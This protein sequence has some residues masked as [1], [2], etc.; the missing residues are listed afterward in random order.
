MK[1]SLRVFAKALLIH[2][3]RPLSPSLP[4]SGGGGRGEEEISSIPLSLTLSPLGGAREPAR[5]ALVLDCNKLRCALL[6]T[7]IGCLAILAGCTVGPDYH[8][9]KENPPTQWVSPQA[10]GE[11]N[12]QATETAWWKSFHDPELDSL[13]A[14]AAQSNLSM[15]VAVARLRQTRAAQKIVSADF[16]PALNTSGSHDRER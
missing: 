4:R 10:G 6:A 8:P 9:P 5:R 11:T 7:E 15:R 16:W 2:L 1:M 12:G 3:Q 13:V 14:R